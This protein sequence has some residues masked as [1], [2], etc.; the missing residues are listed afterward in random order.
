MLPRRQ[1][2]VQF[3]LLGRRQR[4]HRLL[5]MLCLLDR[6]RSRLGGSRCGR[7]AWAA[8]R[9]REG[10]QWHHRRPA[11]LHSGLCLLC[12]RSGGACVRGEPAGRLG[13]ASW[14]E[15]AV[16]RRCIKHSGARAPRC[17]NHS[18]RHGSRQ[19]DH[20]FPCKV[21]WV[22]S[23]CEQ[24]EST[25]CGPTESMIRNPLSP[26]SCIYGRWPCQ[27]RRCAQEPAADV[28]GDS[29][30]FGRPTLERF[31]QPAEQLLRAARS[32]AGKSRPRRR[33]DV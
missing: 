33:Q 30:N 9:R 29:N 2:L 15:A 11:R 23:G 3:G 16:S 21:L 26:N 32:S 28:A 19:H 24:P 7:G 14:A 17:R 1:N 8:G 13:T 6:A 18:P 22:N 27:L 20:A 5:L 25:S 12:P 4:G 31:G 10:R